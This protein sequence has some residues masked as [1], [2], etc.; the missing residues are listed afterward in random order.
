MKGTM[1]A[2]SVIP[3]IGFFCSGGHCVIVTM[4][5]HQAP[6]AVIK[7]VNPLGTVVTLHSS[8]SDTPVDSSIEDGVVIHENCDETLFRPVVVPKMSQSISV[9]P[10]PR[11]T[12]ETPKPIKPRSKHQ[13]TCEI[14]LKSEPRAAEVRNVV[15]VQSDCRSK[16]Q[17]VAKPEDKFEDA[18]ESLSILNQGCIK[19]SELESKLDKAKEK[20]PIR[21]PRKQKTKLGIKIDPTF[22]KS[23]DPDPLLEPTASVDPFDLDL[24]EI[25]PIIDL[26]EIETVTFTAKLPKKSYSSVAKVTSSNIFEIEPPLDFSALDILAPEKS[27]SG[28]GET[29]TESDDSNK[30]LP[31]TE[32]SAEESSLADVLKPGSESIDKT[33]KKKSRKKKKL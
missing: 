33:N 7:V 29:E 27:E 32:K 24:K 21:N 2:H 22:M 8:E 15:V 30:A 13:S 3:A 9:N 23:V 31:L 16:D 25:R 12:V 26:P 11:Q 4:K 6:P 14:K 1:I 18:F 5:P 28:T 10:K 20:L 17:D 19:P